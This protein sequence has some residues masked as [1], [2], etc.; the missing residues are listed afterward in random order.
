MNEIE[1][2]DMWTPPQ[3][4]HSPNL[5][6]GIH[7][8]E[9]IEVEGQNGVPNPFDEK[10]QRD[11]LIVTFDVEGFEVKRTITNSSAPKSTLNKWTRALGYG[12]I[13]L[14]GFRWSDL[15]GKQCRVYITW[16]GKTE[17]GSQWDRVDDVL[18]PEQ[19]TLKQPEHT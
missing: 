11:V 14:T 4:P 17:N 10:K 2:D 12:D 15:I 18:G 8:A 16:S 7:E 1:Q 19:Q 13:S 9:I 5:S 6:V 3:K